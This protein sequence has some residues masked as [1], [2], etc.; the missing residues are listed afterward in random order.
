MEETVEKV[1][2]LYGRPVGELVNIIEDQEEQIKNLSKL[3]REANEK[4]Y[5]AEMRHSGNY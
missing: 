4:R 1:K 5:N 3:L 2:N